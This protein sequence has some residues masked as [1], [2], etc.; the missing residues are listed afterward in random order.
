MV[1][2]VRYFGSYSGASHM[3]SAKTC[4]G[5]ISSASFGVGTRPKII[6]KN[7]V[8]SRLKNIGEAAIMDLPILTADGS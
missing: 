7:A 5:D 8:S 1:R 2:L 4:I 6:Y 3:Y